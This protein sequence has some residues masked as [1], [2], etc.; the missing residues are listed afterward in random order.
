MN[1]YRFTK[2]AKNQS[3]AAAAVAVLAC[4]VLAAA[5]VWGY[6]WLLTFLINYVLASFG[7]KH[8]TMLLVFVCNLLLG[9]LG[10]RLR[11]TKESA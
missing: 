11:G 4:L 8:V 5:I 1:Q 7:L 3:A 6:I 9:L 2:A 10:R